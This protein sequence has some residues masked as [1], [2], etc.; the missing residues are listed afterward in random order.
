MKKDAAKKE[1]PKE[2]MLL[3]RNRSQGVCIGLRRLK[4]TNPN[5]R[6]AIEGMLEPAFSCDDLELLKVSVYS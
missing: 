1:P 4:M 3:T 5:L 2:I 6:C